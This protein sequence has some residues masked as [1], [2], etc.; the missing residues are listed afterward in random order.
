MYLAGQVRALADRGHRVALAVYGA[1]EGGSIAGVELLRARSVPLARFHTG[2]LHWSRPLGDLALARVVRRYCAQHPV[3]II[4]AHNVEGPLVA[5]LARTGRPI[6][7]DLHTT[8]VQE[9]P[10]HLPRWLRPLGRPMGAL[11]DGLALR[12]AD[13]GC[14]ISPRAERRLRR[15]GFPVRL[16]GPGVDP[17]DLK[18]GPDPRRRLG[19]PARFVIYTG[20]LDRYQD[21]PILLRAMEGLDVPLVVVTGSPDPLPPWVR[22]IRSRSYRDAID[23]LSVATLAVIPRRDCAGFPIKL[24]NQLGMGCPTVM[25]ASAALPL[26][27]VVIAEPSQLRSTVR[28]LLADPVRLARLGADG[29]R[30]VREGWT[31]SKR[32][33]RLEALYEDVVGR[34]SGDSAGAVP[35]GT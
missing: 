9:L 35:R 4:H 2:G 30:A 7:Y 3:D 8:M 5:R 21:L 22:V 12:V 33:E 20:N 25:L 27:G 24:L 19:L 14:A 16:V 15:A 11:V 17:N 32:A 26:P 1:G 18:P 10:C 13:A 34:H 6:V 28:E 23:A 31:W 29:R